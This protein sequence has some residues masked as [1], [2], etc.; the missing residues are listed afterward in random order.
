LQQKSKDAIKKGQ[1]SIQRST[2]NYTKVQEEIEDNRREINEAL[3]KLNDE[4]KEKLSKIKTQETETL[5]SIEVKANQALTEL[6]SIS[7]DIDAHLNKKQL[8]QLFIQMKTTEKKLMELQET[9]EELKDT[10]NSDITFKPNVELKKLLK[11]Q[12]SFGY[13]ITENP[14][15]AN[16]RYVK[17]IDVKSKNNTKTCRITGMAQLSSDLLVMADNQNA[18]IKLVDTNTN[19]ILCEAMLD[20]LPWD[21][22]TLD[23]ENVAVTVPESKKI[24]FFRYD[25]KSVS[26]LNAGA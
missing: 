20:A 15:N 4:L 12:D 7:S 16:A 14:K 17:N 5:N 19:A 1:E 23:S 3:D 13:L 18:S 2:E 22:T 10:R 21:V 9:M 11:R 25:K 8:C 26:K 6:E 24:L